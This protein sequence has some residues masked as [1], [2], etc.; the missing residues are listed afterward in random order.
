MKL[1]SP[2]IKP[3]IIPLLLSL[4][5]ITAAMTSL[6]QSSPP[7]LSPELQ[8]VV[9]LAR[10][11]I[12]DDVIIN[13]IQTSGK[14]YKLSAD[15]I[16]YL[17]SQGVPQN[18]IAL[19]QTTTT[20][21]NSPQTPPVTAAPQPDPSSPVPPPLD[22]S[23]L[24]PAPAP[25]AVSALPAAFSYGLQDSFFADGALNNA[26]WQ[27]DSG[28]LSALASMNGS[29]VFP[30][31]SFSP[32]GM[33]MSGTRGPGQFMGIQSVASFAPPFN[34]TATVS[35]ATQV[36]IPF[37]IYL[38]TADFQEWLSIAGHVGGRGTASHG[39][40]INHTG[41]G[42]PV[43]SLGRKFYEPLQ[44]GAPYIIQVSATPEGAA[45]VSM[46][47]SAGNMLAARN[48]RLGNGPFYVILAGRN[49]PV[50]STWQSV[51]LTPASSPV[52]EQPVIPSAPTL[53]YFQSQLAPY[54]NWVNAPGYG[55]CWQP[56]VSIGWRPYFD[57]GHW[58]YTDAGWYWQSDYP[59][60]DIA[61]HYGRWAYTATG[62]VWVPG[63]E[64]APAW[65][66]WRHDDADGFVGWAPLPPGAVFVNGIWEFNHVRI[67]ADFDF[68]LSLDFFAFVGFDHFWEHDFRHFVVPHDRLALVFRHSVIENHYRFDHGRFINDGLARERMTALTHHDIRVA[69]V[70][71]I[72]AHEENRN[73]LARRDDIHSFKLGATPDARRIAPE[74]VPAPQR[75]SAPE[76][77]GQPGKTQFG[78]GNGQSTIRG[79]SQG[80]GKGEGAQ[81]K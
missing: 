7:I 71:D 26:L 68:G 73:A 15:D 50:Y 61:F 14:A 77:H 6:A 62:W 37:E 45:S 48:V 63:Y 42:L 51:Q 81:S 13:Y 19:L 64:Y 72:R 17:N 12:S 56:A 69:T 70:H 25:A 5:L 40:W 9:R 78:V 30:M 74:R 35:A 79:N 43:S 66:V 39:V 27:T 18:I 41:S 22:S 67:G 28:V 59:W 44:T 24:S 75:N 8:Q 34:F 32:A 76:S 29:R 52:A 38:V 46:L 10:Q 2:I 33:Q 54:G 31:L 20:R 47:D 36:A 80:G 1:K 65:V 16:I 60:G 23:S 4:S 58:E 55:L 57:E 53:D 21:T 11:H 3:V 49:G